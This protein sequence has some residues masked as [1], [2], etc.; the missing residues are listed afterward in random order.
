MTGRA[1]IF[2][3]H[4]ELHKGKFKDRRLSSQL[5]DLRFIRPDVAIG[6][7]AFAG[8][9]TSTAVDER[10]ATMALATIVLE[11]EQGRWS[12]AAF[13]NTLLT[14]SGPVAPVLPSDPE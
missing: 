3:Y 11:K 12:I 9:T 2:T 4:D 7:V 1:A 10:G 6:H 8:K 5:K 13:H 14:R